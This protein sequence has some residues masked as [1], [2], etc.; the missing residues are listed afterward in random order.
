[1][2]RSVELWSLTVLLLFSANAHGQADPRST[3]QTSSHEL[4]S[5]CK[6]F[7]AIPHMM[8]EGH[9]LDT[10]VVDDGNTCLTFFVG[11]AEG[12]NATALHWATMLEAA[13]SSKSGTVTS[14]QSAQAAVLRRFYTQNMYCLKEGTTVD[15]II[16]FYVNHML[17]NPQ[18]LNKRP[19]V[20]VSAALVKNFPCPQSDKP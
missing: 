6:A 18:D 7:L 11:F 2:I 12:S 13:Q 20:T 16:W 4:V 17:A 5:A 19:A 3:L 9:S 10:K 15:N 8:E 14:K 1:M